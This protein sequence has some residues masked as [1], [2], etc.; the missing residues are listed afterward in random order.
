MHTTSILCINVK[1]NILESERRGKKKYFYDNVSIN[2]YIES[3]RFHR[4]YTIIHRDNIIV[5][6]I[7]I[8]LLPLFQFSPFGSH[9]TNHHEKQFVCF[10]PFLLLRS[11]AK[12]VQIIPLGS[13][14]HLR[15]HFHSNIMIIIIIKIT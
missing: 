8:L 15:C 1:I 10:V 5:L 2:E 3:E 7:C 9:C 11:R 13:K 12:N 14:N 4:A 6:Y